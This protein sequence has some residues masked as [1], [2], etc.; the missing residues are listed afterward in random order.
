M[1]KYILQQIRTLVNIH[2]YYIIIYVCIY[3]Y[4]TL[5]L[6]QNIK[7]QSVFNIPPRIV[8]LLYI[9]VHPSN[10]VLVLLTLKFTYKT[11]KPLTVPNL[12]FSTMFH[13]QMAKKKT[14]LI[15][16]WGDFN[17]Y[18]LSHVF[19]FLPL[20]DQLF[21]PPCV[22][23]AWL[24]ATLDTLF[25]NSVLDLTLIDR[26]KNKIQ[27]L[28]F[29]YLL[30]LAINEY[31]GWVSIYLPKKYMLGYFG[32]VYIAEKTPMML[33]AFMPC[34]AGLNALAVCISLPYWKKLKVFRARLK[35]SEGLLVISQLAD[36]CKNIVEIGVHGKMTMDEVSCIIEGFPQLKILDIS[37]STLCHRALIMIFD[38]KLKF[39]RELNILHCSIYNDDGKVISHPTTHVVSMKYNKEMREKASLLKSV[40]VL[41]CL[42]TSCQHYRKKS[43][44]NKNLL[45]H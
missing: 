26:L 29:T 21:G 5:L 9:Y 35:P 17:P 12:Q 7:P 11:P 18:L 3:I 8:L 43:L 13:S 27:R 25:H 30:R 14:Q 32:M 34:D 16:P 38:G 10:I 4:P 23:H 37:C 41:H 20:H 22:C 19:S 1:F 2:L 24:S 36:Y 42:G 28:R 44:R 40:K 33:S 45:S 39:L 6:I 15:P 31:H